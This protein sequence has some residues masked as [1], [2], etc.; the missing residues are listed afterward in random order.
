MTLGSLVKISLRGD[1]SSTEHAILNAKSILLASNI[2][3]DSEI[4]A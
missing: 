3:P 4:H 2:T 1:N